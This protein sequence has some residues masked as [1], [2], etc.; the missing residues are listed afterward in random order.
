MKTLQ[1]EVKHYNNLIKNLVHQ[2]QDYWKQFEQIMCRRVNLHK[3][4][5]NKSTSSINTRPMVL[6]DAMNIDK[7]NENLP[8]IDNS[9]PVKIPK[10]RKKK[11]TCIS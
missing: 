1:N 9:S 11:I 3:L 10:I 5:L 8:P 6:V 7:N 2:E 4:P